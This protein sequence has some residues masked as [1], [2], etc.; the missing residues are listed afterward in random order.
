MAS[1]CFVAPALSGGQSRF[2]TV[3]THAERNSRLGVPQAQA[4]DTIAD[5]INKMTREEKDRFIS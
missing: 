5:A 1:I 3:A 2:H 4:C